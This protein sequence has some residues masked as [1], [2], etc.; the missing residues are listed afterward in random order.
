[1]KLFFRSFFFLGTFLFLNLALANREK[2]P[3]GYWTC[4]FMGHEWVSV[5]GPNGIPQQQYQL[6]SYSSRWRVSKTQAYNEALSYCQDW[7]DDDCEYS[8]C[9]QK[10]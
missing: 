9:R 4:S 1:M 6:R 7:S 3:A 2:V 5:P 8:G 10:H